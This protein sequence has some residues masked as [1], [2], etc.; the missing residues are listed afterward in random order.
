MVES[1]WQVM[2]LLL[3]VVLVSVGGSASGKVAI[4]GVGSGRRDAEL[5]IDTCC[6]PSHARYDIAFHD[7]GTW[8][9]PAEF[10]RYGVVVI[11]NLKGE[12]SR[13]WTAAEVQT[14]LDYVEAGGHLVVNAVAAM[15]LGGDGRNVSTLS[16]LLG[17][18]YV[19]Q[20]V[21][22]SAVLDRTHPLTAHL[23]R[24]DYGW[25]GAGL[26]LG[27]VTTAR[28]LIGST[29]PEV[30]AAVAVN[31]V[32]KGRVVFLNQE[33]FR[34]Y[35]GRQADADAYGGIVEA[36][37][38]AV[39][40]PV[41][42]ARERWDPTP[43]GPEVQPVAAVAAARKRE[44]RTTRRVSPVT[45][46]PLTLVENGRPTCLIVA[47]TEPTAAA[48]KG[49]AELQRA[50]RRMTGFEAESCREAEIEWQLA[51]PTPRLMKAGRVLSAVVVVGDTAAGRELGVDADA[52]PLEGFRLVTR[53]PLLFVLGCDAAPNGLP[54]HGTLHGVVSLLERHFGFRWLWPGELGEVVPRC[55]TLRLGPLDETDAPALRQ[56]KLRNSGVVGLAL[57]QPDIVAVDGQ[58]VG[59]DGKPEPLRAYDRLLRGLARLGIDESQYLSKH[60]ESFPWFVRQRLGSSLRLHYTHA[61]GGWWERFGAEH[62][63]WFALQSNGLRSQ[64]PPRE[65]LCVSNE[66][67]AAAVAREA[68]RRFGE[69]PTLDA[70]SISPNDGS[71]R[72]HFCMCEHCRRLDPPKAPSVQLMHTRGKVRF[73][74]DYPSLTDRFVTFYSRVAG[75]VAD[76]CPDRWLG[77]YAYSVYRSAPLYADVHPNLLIGFV[78]LGYFDDHKLELDRQRWDGWAAK[79]TNLFLR[80]NLLHG[81]HGFPAVYVTKLGQDLKH[82][83]ETGMLAADFD[84]VMHHWATH[85]LNYY[86]LAKLLWDPSQDA[87]EI[88]SDYCE[89]GFGAA[90]PPVQRYFAELEAL[91]DEIAANAA[92]QSERELRGEEAGPGQ[93]LEF[94]QF[95]VPERLAALGTLLDQARAA[96]E[97][98]DVA[99]RVDFLRLGLRYAGLQYRIRSLR[100]APGEVD[101]ERGRRA[102]DERHAFYVEL[103]QTHPYAVNV[104]WLLWREGSGLTRAFGWRPPSVR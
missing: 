57:H 71:S 50:F 84:S 14:A 5:I 49:V 59:A 25:L 53:P 90:A 33:W 45:G 24:D 10:A 67:L 101:A 13:A 40:K 51:G 20:S 39:C 23:A 63:D 94:W 58:P 11:C 103:L 85:G 65:R 74:T 100:A 34:L 92:Q 16:A 75:R 2:R 46:E 41:A 9:E 48:A 70:S 55:D 60:R 35:Q 61:Y 38:R 89:K 30:A 97:R 12:G 42:S 104:G 96:A 32:G 66:E 31:E 72:N 43:L 54:L 29:E 83:Y 17:G 82:C 6:L 88:V 26:V 98:E 91:T 64:D 79:A 7:A 62:P 21:A 86:V 81:G 77:A 87:G 15:K 95:Y 8:L 22:Q 44:A 69:E 76:V 52:L 99:A 47:A 19:G 37:I 56:R 68:I 28:A 27:K 3:V 80:P 78:G 1:R 93:R 4:F 73:F 102:L 36:A 18:A